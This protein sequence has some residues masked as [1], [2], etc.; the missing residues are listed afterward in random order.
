LI[1]LMLDQI[2]E[3]EDR[4]LSLHIISLFSNDKNSMV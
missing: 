1:Y 4:E 3:E 2:R